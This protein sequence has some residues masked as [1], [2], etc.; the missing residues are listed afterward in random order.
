MVKLSD[1]NLL[2]TP[3][4]TSFVAILRIV[5][6]STIISTIMSVIAVVG[7]MLAYISSRLKKRSMRL[8]TSI[9]LSLSE[10]VSLAAWEPWA[11]EEAAQENDVRH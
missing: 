11:L 10:L 9:S 8:K 2:N 4:F 7:V 3:R 6:T 1:I 5:S